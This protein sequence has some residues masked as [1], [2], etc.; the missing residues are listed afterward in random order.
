[1]EPNGELIL[2]IGR[3]EGKVDTLVANQQST[4]ARIDLIETR[5]S[6]LEQKMA[7]AAATGSTGN[8]WLSNLIALGALVISVGAIILDKVTG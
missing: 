1:M 8:R 2:L 6:Q 4:A 7:A 3:I 5:T